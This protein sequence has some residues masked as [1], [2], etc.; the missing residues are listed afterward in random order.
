M[1]KINLRKLRKSMKKE[2]SPKR[3]EH[4]LAVAYTAA[5]LAMVHGADAEQALIAGMLHDCAKCLPEQRLIA[6]CKKHN[7]YITK[8]ERENA[9]ALL[10]A[11]VG[12]FLAHEKYGIREEEILNAIKYHTTGRPQM[13]D[14]EKILYIADYIEPGRKPVPQLTEIRQAAYR[15]LD[16]ALLMILDNTLAYLEKSGNHIDPLTKET[17]A[18]YKAQ[19]NGKAGSTAKKS[20]AAK[21]S[22]NKAEIKQSD[23]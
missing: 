12:S 13:S 1:K 4:T 6:L 9:S 8:V 21:E 16:E 19:G 17:Y 2:L 10:H 23:T 22:I 5:T 3:Y 15:S 14:M 11:K 20:K 7:L 18:Y